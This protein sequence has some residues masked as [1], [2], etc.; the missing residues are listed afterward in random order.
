[1]TETTEWWQEVVQAGKR[2]ELF[3]PWVLTGGKWK[4][5]CMI[6]DKIQKTGGDDS[7]LP[8]GDM[9][10]SCPIPKSGGK[11]NFSKACGDHIAKHYK[12]LERAKA[13]ADAP[14]DEKEMENDQGSE[15]EDEQTAMPLMFAT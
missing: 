4:A 9:Y 5:K 14:V 2:A 13:A 10:A 1:M 8:G 7:T 11:P 3:G 6:C 15:H 12:A